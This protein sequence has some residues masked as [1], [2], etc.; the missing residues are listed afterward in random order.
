MCARRASSFDGQSVM[1]AGKTKIAFNYQC[2]NDFQLTYGTADRI[3]YASLT[4]LLHHDGKI[5]QRAL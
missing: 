4:I 2:N 5:T 1:V 3:P